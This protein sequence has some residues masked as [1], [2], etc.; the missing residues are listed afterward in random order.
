M[1]A[2]SLTFL[3]PQTKK[4]RRWCSTA[5]TVYQQVLWTT[6]TRMGM[7]GISGLD[8]LNHPIH[9]SH[10]ALRH[11]YLLVTAN[12]RRQES[13][14]C[15]H[16][17]L[18][19]RF[20]SRLQVRV[21]GPFYHCFPSCWNQLS[22]INVWYICWGIDLRQCCSL[23]GFWPLW[24]KIKPAKPDLLLQKCQFRLGRNK[25]P[26]RRRSYLTIDFVSK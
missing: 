23:A 10:D 12:R 13:V 15:L 22:C 18:E 20:W 21:E 17:W 5:D 4:S 1:E 8:L 19:F 9:F 7:A 2:F 26:P 24:N 16:Q 25:Q 11:R 14:E 3:G 6:G